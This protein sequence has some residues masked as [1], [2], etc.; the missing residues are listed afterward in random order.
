M[1][2]Y[3]IIHE[4]ERFVQ[5]QVEKMKEFVIRL[6]CVKDVEKFVALSTAQPFQVTLDDGQHT[7]NGKTFMEMFCLILT[8]PLRVRV[9]CTDEE[10]EAF[11]AEAARFII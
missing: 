2:L 5:L 8:R 7:V 4:K 6:S 9:Q 1:D 10:F 11:R 3:P